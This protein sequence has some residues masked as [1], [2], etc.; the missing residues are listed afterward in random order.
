MTAFVVLTFM[1]AIAIGAYGFWA[2]SIAKGPTDA[3]TVVIPKGSGVRGTA[4][5]LERAGI[6]ANDTI[7]MAGIKLHGAERDLKAGEYLIPAGATMREVMALLRSG[8]TV[9]RRFTVA[10][11][12]SVRQVVAL[13][14]AEP[15][16]AGEVADMPPEGSL[17]PE[18]YHFAYGDSRAALVQRMRT[19]MRDTLARLW[20]ERA[21][22]LPVSTPQEALILASIVE[23]ETSVPAERP[24][25][26]SVFVNRLRIGM[27]LQSDPTI[28]YGIRGGEKLGRPILQ[29]DLASDTPYNTY[30]ITGLPPTP[31]A[32][33]GI[34]SLRA[35]LNPARTEDFY[36]VADGSGGH[37]FART[38][39][40][41]LRNVQ[42]WRAIERQG[43][44]R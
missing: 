24:R 22:D 34:E 19:A 33:P 35:V 25:V 15:A 3:A 16:L 9:I 44:A 10:E 17:M 18:T 21:N 5:L 36:F 6:I 37:A 28:V 11:G 40:E 23:K 7:F 20:E 32:N 43:G 38:Y 26:A 2:F 14:Q 42:R 4:S 8:K 30:K 1:G 41:H 39:E 27:P 31:I 29:S 13:L 12:L